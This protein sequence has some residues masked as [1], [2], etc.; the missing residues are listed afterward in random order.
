MKRTELIQKLLHFDREVDLQYGNRGLECKCYIVG[1][2]ALVLMDCIP[3]ATHDIDVI[4]AIPRTISSMMEK[5]DI[6]INVSAY[7]TSFAEG[8]ANRATKLEIE[9]RC[10]DFYT[11]SLED[12]IVSKLASGRD[13]DLFDIKQ[14]DLLKRIDWDLL[15]EL[16]ELVIEGMVSD[17]DVQALR[18]NYQNFKEEFFR[19]KT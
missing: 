3:R 10:V 16:V 2:S 1:G 18:T 19:E 4:E 7:N 6:N 14:P 15:G 11:L 12:L 9:S 13:K 17:W 8:Y 5:Y